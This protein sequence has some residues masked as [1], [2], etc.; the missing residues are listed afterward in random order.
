MH[1][2]GASTTEL[3]KVVVIIHFRLHKPN[4]LRGTKQA[5]AHPILLGRGTYMEGV[6]GD[7]EM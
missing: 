7:P 6:G 5:S 1:R 2:D 3:P 4:E